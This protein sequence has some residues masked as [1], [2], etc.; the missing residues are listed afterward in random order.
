[1]Q[2]HPK[3]LYHPQLPAT[4]VDDSNAEE[5]LG[6]GWFDTPAEAQEAAALAA[7]S[8]SGDDDKITEAERLELLELARSMGLKP[9]HRL[10][11]DKLLTLIEEE[12]ARVAAQKNEA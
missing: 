6:D 8:G 3:W 12:R 4:M 7:S 10:A 1:M 9:H 2:T 5:A 11:A